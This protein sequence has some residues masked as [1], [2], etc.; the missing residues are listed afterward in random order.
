MAY[1]VWGKD[2][3]GSL[4]FPQTSCATPV[5][6]SDEMMCATNRRYHPDERHSYPAQNYFSLCIGD[7]TAALA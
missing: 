7:G 4:V 6:Y 5:G 2:K 1:T 3:N